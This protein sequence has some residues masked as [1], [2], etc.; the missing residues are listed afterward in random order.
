MELSIFCSQV[1]TAYH[2]SSV[3]IKGSNII[4]LAQCHGQASLPRYRAVKSS[5]GQLGQNLVKNKCVS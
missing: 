3:N 5:V 1:I 2:L 4:I